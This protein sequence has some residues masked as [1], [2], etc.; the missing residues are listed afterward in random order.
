V[1]ITARLRPKRIVILSSAPQI[2]FPDCYGIDMSKMKDFVAF[3]ALVKLLEE[4]G[5][6]KLLEETYLRCKHSEMLPVEA[7]Q[8]EVI[9]LYEHFEYTQISDKIA[10][11]VKPKD[12]K[13]QLY[14]MFQTLEGLHQACPGNTGDWYFSGR[15]PTP[16]GNR[17]ANR[18][19]MNFVEKKD[20]RAY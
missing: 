10:E 16:G 20:E 12:L 2:R 19:F 8:N 14:V 11:I 9:E 18:A 17:V 7:V 6:E 1:S 4:N 5:M 3:Q 15:Y 13:P